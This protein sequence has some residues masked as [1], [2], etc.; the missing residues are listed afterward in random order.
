MSYMELVRYRPGEAIRWLQTGAENMRKAAGQ[1]GKGLVTQSGA[2]Q[3]GIGENVRTAAGALF[4]FGKS[5]YAEVVHKQ[6][7]TVEYV[8][9]DEHFDVVRGASINTVP[10]SRIKKISLGG[11]RVKIFLDKGTM[12]IKPVAHILAGRLKVPV[13]WVRNGIEVP[14][15]LLP[16]ELAARCGLDLEET[17]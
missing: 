17:G 2:E 9:Q 11:D 16:D 7:E 12:T 1:R 6:A 3:K 15:D 5:A 10:Y 14:F 8:L 4:D 13:G